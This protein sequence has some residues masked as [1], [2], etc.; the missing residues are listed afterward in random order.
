MLKNSII[1]LPKNTIPVV[2][3]GDV[4]E[5][6]RQLQDK[7]IDVIIT[8]PPYYKQR[9]YGVEGEIGWEK[10]SDEYVKKMVDV[11]KELRRVLK[12]SG[13]YWLNIGDKYISK[14]LQLIP[15]KVAIGMQE[16]HWIV[17]DIII[18][19]KY[20]NPMPTSIRNRFNAVYEPIIFFIKDS[21][22]YYV[23][24]YH[25]NLDPLRIPQLTNFDTDLPLTLSNE[26]YKKMESE[27]KK[28]NNN[29]SNS[30]FIGHE[31]N[32]GASPGARQIL[33]GEYYTQ[34]RK[35]KITKLLKEEIITY[36]KKHRKKKGISSAEIDELL[37]KKDTAG[38]W[39]RLDPGGSIPLPEDWWNLKKILGF[40]NKYDKI[41][42]ETHWV[43]QTVKHH[44]KGKTPENIW[45]MA[46]GKLKYAH[47]SIFPTELPE[48]IIKV[49]CPKKDKE[50]LP[51]IVLDPFAGSGTTGEAA[52][53]LGRRSILIDLK[54]DYVDI[55]KKRCGEINVI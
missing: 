34:Q 9:E 6:I 36:L 43:L 25:F 38:H 16:N 18:W 55:I 29:N 20:P 22:K 46:P 1:E 2:L 12:D 44:P 35:H 52:K 28:R 19:H 45:K 32:R 3:I 10:T 54:K 15:Y 17:R 7:C 49:C 39:F 33:Y 13:S 26:E 27:L 40:N 48:K 23:Y 53:K 31:N 50:G 42:A 11:G 47:F 21:G 5:K 37:G 51:G 30:K 24:D 14:K 4:I 8:S 41:V